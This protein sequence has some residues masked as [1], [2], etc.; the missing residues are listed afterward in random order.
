MWMLRFLTA[1][2]GLFGRARSPAMMLNLTVPR[3]GY[4][5]QRDFAYG[6]APR[7]RYD[8]YLP[9]ALTGP[10]PIVLFFYGGAFRA[11]R[12]SEY[13][14]VGEALTSKG[15]I[16]AV[17][18]YRIYPEAR[19][20][21]FLDDGA[22][23]L[24]AVHARAAEF[25]GDPTRIFLAGH[26]A[27]AYIAVMLASNPAYVRAANADLSWIRGIIPMAGRYHKIPLADA[28]GVTIFGGPAREETRPASFIDGKRPAM[29]LL[30]GAAES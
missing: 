12:K 21:D 30:A 24:A 19:F 10:A 16:V 4:R 5:V 18:D 25:G 17:A 1:V 14:V 7:Q 8:L 28:A 23:A 27:G 20:P 3:S 26:S 29:L 6:E 2:L 11:G 22:K 9:K 15:I 13:R